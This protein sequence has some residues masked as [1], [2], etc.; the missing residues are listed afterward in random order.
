MTFESFT[1]GYIIYLLDVFLPGIGFG[2]LLDIW[3][4]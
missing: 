3:G 2:E 1:P 4:E